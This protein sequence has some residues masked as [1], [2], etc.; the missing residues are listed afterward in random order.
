MAASAPL[1]TFR[2]SGSR[3]EGD[4][5][6]QLFRLPSILAV[7]AALCF[8][9]GCSKRGSQSQGAEP[10]AST[11]PPAPPQPPPSMAQGAPPPDDAH[12]KHH[13]K[14]HKGVSE[15]NC[16]MAVPGAVARAEDVPEGVALVLSTPEP[17]Q[18]AELQQRSRRMLHEQAASTQRAQETS[19]LDEVQRE[20][21]GD[22]DTEEQ[23]GRDDSGTGGA[24]MAGAPTMPSSASVQD[25]P[26]GVVIVYTAMDPSQQQ[27]LSSEVHQ[28]A[29]EMKPG[30][31]PGM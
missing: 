5:H 19:V 12:G 21:L 28:T 24:G 4:I 14:H 26:D 29:N 2:E 7:S 23:Y 27:Q 18:V 15:A 17:T 13:G 22:S 11:Q 8:S 9:V 20:D 25:T 6:M 3:P 1:S 16:P 30:Q 10:Q 31:C